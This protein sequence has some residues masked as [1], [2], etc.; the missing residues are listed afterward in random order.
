MKE[1]TS[2]ILVFLLLLFSVAAAEAGDFDV[3]LTCPAS[4]AAGTPLSADVKLINNDCYQRVVVDRAVAGIGGNAGGSLGS[5]GIW[6]PFNRNISATIVPKATCDQWG[7][8][9]TPGKKSLPA[10]NIVDSVPSS[11]AGTAAMAVFEVIT[12]TGDGIGGESCLVEVTP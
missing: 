5:M 1:N 9:I 2:V 4:V 10:F 3:E 11:L 8:V 6:G 12:Q 7:N